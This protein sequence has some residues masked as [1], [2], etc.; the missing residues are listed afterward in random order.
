METERT[1]L[2]V[3]EEIPEKTEL[4]GKEYKITGVIQ[5]GYYL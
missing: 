3:W 4:D 5:T 2:L 1:I